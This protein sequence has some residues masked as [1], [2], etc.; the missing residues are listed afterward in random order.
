MF[1]AN[2]NIPRP[3]VEYLREKGF[4]V[5]S[6]QD[7]HQG[8]TDLSVIEMARAEDLII[9]TFD[10]DYGELIFRHEIINPP[11]VIFIRYKGTDPEYAGRLMEALWKSERF[12]FRKAFTVIDKHGIRQKQYLPRL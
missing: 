5:K 3:S 8:V 10:R 12:D 4:A 7:L 1:L 2:E 9:L 11:P 6:I